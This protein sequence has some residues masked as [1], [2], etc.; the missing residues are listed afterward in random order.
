MQVYLKPTADEV[1]QWTWYASA[2][3]APFYQYLNTYPFPL[4][5]AAVSAKT[6]NPNI[7]YYRAT[8]QN[9]PSGIKDI[10]AV[11]QRGII[12]NN[13]SPYTYAGLYINGTYYWQSPELRWST[14]SSLTEKSYTWTVNP[15]TSS[16]WSEGG[17]NGTALAY[18]HVPTGAGYVAV[19]TGINIDL[20]FTLGGGGFAYLMASILPPIIAASTLVAR[21]WARVK[22]AL[23]ERFRF[24]EG[25]WEEARRCRINHRWTRFA[26]QRS[27]A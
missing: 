3:P 26:F 13:S 24:G 9:C 7:N 20:T 16:V 1:A 2:Y 8:M 15:D 27:F 19:T 18:R 6:S 23:E 25:E 21:E 4:S 12:N 11:T 17:L 22:T 14:E 5:G 10:L